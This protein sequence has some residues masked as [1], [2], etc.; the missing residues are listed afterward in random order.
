MV[1]SALLAAGLSAGGSLIS[2]LGASASA[3]KQ[4]RLQAIADAQANQYNEGMIA[5]VNKQNAALGRDLGKR[6]LKSKLVETEHVQGSIT[7]TEDSATDNYSYVDVKGM[8]DAAEAAG[9]NPVTFL[10]AGG[11]QAYTQT[12]SRSHAVSSEITDM[13]TTRTSKGHNAAAA[14]QLMAG[15]MSPQAYQRNSTQINRVPSAGEA[16]GDAISSGSKAGF[17]QYNEDR[18][19]D[20]KMELLGKQ[21]DAIQKASGKPV[22]GGRSM[23]IPSTTTSGSTTRNSVGGSLGTGPAISG[24]F[25]KETGKYTDPWGGQ[26]GMKV[27]PKTSDAETKSDRYGDIAEE[28]AGGWNI[29]NDTV[30]SATGRNIPYFARQ[31]WGNFEKNLNL[32]GG[33]ETVGQALERKFGPWMD[34]VFGKPTERGFR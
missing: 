2:G 17:Q 23:Y 21:L 9:F 25:E 12:G 34:M 27:D 14:F 1:W 11:M 29:I 32:K 20:L 28:L 6:L 31:G 15:L 10:N 13:M 26:F 30:Y 3:A 16:V 8:M 7:R 24:P 5:E 33:G 18:D 4:N 22:A 19:R